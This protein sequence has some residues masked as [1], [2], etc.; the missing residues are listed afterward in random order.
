MRSPNTAEHQQVDA[1]DEQDHRA[2]DDQDALD[3]RG[4]DRERRRRAVMVAHLIGLMQ[5]LF[6][7]PPGTGFWIDRM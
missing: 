6:F 3:E 4:R 7:G 2:D 5:T 1:A